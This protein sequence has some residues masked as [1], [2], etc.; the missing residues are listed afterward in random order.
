M[1]LSVIGRKRACIKE[2]LTKSYRQ[3]ADQSEKSDFFVV[4]QEKPFDEPLS[5][6]PIKLHKE[7]RFLRNLATREML[8]IATKIN[9]K[10]IKKLQFLSA[11][12]QQIGRSK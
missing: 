1:K 4:C 5:I 11:R 7:F 10:F 12:I 2:R 6:I 9:P 8:K 3:L